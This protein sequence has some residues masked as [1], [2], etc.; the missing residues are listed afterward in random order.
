MRRTGIEDIKS[1]AAMIIQSERFGTSLSQALKVYAE[2]LR[3][4]R[5]LRAE[6]GAKVGAGTRRRRAKI[7]I[8]MD[9]V[10][11][12]PVKDPPN[13]VRAGSFSLERLLSH[14]DPGPAEESE[15]FVHLIYEQR[16]IDLC[17]HGNGKTCR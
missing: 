15:A 4:R 12:Q 8:K 1:L 5:R 17:S 16:L 3:T 6:A 13:L 9:R 11:P 10:P 2:A 14:I 7:V